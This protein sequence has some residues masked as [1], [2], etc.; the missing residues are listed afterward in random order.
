MST[1]RTNLPLGLWSPTTG[2]PSGAARRPKPLLAVRG[3]ATDGPGREPVDPS[4]TAFEAAMASLLEH[5]LEPR[6]EGLPTLGVPVATESSGASVE[7][8]AGSPRPSPHVVAMAMVRRLRAPA[9]GHAGPPPDLG[10]PPRI[11][12][13]SRSALLSE[14]VVELEHPGLGPLRLD[15]AMAAGAIE[16]RASVAT[17][18]AAVALRR[19]EGL[20]RHAIVEHGVEL[21]GMRVQVDKR[22]SPARKAQRPRWQNLDQEA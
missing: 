21:R 6:L 22:L 1:Q 19:S 9:P 15:F 7:V 4:D 10:P 16:V 20:M 2:D 11:Q 17:D 13:S 14:T 18:A 5:E 8:Q 3:V 12:V